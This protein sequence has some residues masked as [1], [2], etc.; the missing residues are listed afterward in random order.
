VN[1][2]RRLGIWW[3]WGNQCNGNACWGAVPGRVTIPQSWAD[4]GPEFVSQV[5]IHELT[6]GID[7]WYTGVY[8]SYKGS[9]AGV[10]T[11]IRAGQTQAFHI[12]EKGWVGRFD[13]S[14]ITKSGYHRTSEEA[15]I[16]LRSDKFYSDYYK[17]NPASRPALKI[18]FLLGNPAVMSNVRPKAAAQSFPQASMSTNGLVFGC[19]G[20]GLVPIYD[21]T[22]ISSGYGW[23]PRNYKTG[24]YR[25]VGGMPYVASPL[26]DSAYIWVSVGGV[27]YS[28]P[29]S[30][31]CRI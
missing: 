4:G 7:D 14:A 2:A 18:P 29:R 25:W 20:F 31:V 10:W 24:P 9:E 28:T 1:E 26:R 22:M 8:W 5:I 3:Q 19:T 21:A 13:N 17:L 15:A 23:L 30:Y 11:E 6:H 16:W 12:R 27:W